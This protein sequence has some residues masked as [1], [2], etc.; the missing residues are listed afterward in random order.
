MSQKMS[1]KSNP[2]KGWLIGTSV[3]ISVISRLHSI[4]GN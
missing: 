4:S 1:Q 2:V 3:K